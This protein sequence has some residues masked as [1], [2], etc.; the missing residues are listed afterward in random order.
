M[1]KSHDPSELV[2]SGASHYIP[3]HLSPVDYAKLKA[4]L[5]S[6]KFWTTATAATITTY[7]YASGELNAESYA[8]AVALIS[9][10]YIGSVAI[11]DGLRGLINIWME[12]VP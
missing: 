3:F 11:E 9:G 2:S 6:R 5:R 4:L 12:P 1:P 10:I 7:L 8:N